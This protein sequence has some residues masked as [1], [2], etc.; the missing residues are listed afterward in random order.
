MFRDNK[1]ILNAGDKLKEALIKLTL[2]TRRS[3]PHSEQSS[4][5]SLLKY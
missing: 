3:R 1:P 4:L 2:G 5:R